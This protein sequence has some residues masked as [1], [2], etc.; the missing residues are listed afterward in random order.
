M[1]TLTD[2]SLNL[3]L[4]T[5]FQ[6][7]SLT[8]FPK[9]KIGLVGVNGSGKTTLF[10]M[11]LGQIHPDK[12][13]VLL[14]K[15]IRIAVVEQETPGLTVTALE[16]VRQGDRELYS[17]EEKLI[18]AT[19]KGAAVLIAE[20]HA[21]IAEIDGYSAKSRAA[22]LLHGLGFSQSE[23]EQPV[24]SFSGG[25]RMRLN[26]AQALMAR[27]D[28]LL[29]D[30]PTNHL[31]LEAIVWLEQYLKNYLGTLILVSHDREF[32][33]QVC[34]DTVHV[35]HQQLTLYS[36]NYSQFERIYAEKLANQQ[37]SFEKQQK[38]IDH[39]TSFVNRFRAKASKAKQAQ[40]RLKA[41]EKMERV[42]EVVS[43]LPFNFQFPEVNTALNPLMTIEHADLGYG[44]KIIV[45]NI[46][47]QLDKNAR[48]GLLG[49]NGAGK[50]TFIKFLAGELPALKGQIIRA[51][52]LKIGYFAQHQLEY[53]NAQE[54]PLQHLQKLNINR[55]SDQ[56][57]RNFLGGFNFRGNTVSDPITNFSGGEKA[58][59]ALAL[60]IWQAPHLLLLDEPTNHLDMEMRQALILALQQ[61]QGAMVIISHD[62]YLLSVTV[63][64]FLMINNEK[65]MPFSGDLMD[66]Q[67]LVEQTSS[68][69]N[70]A[71]AKISENQDSPTN[72]KQQN[73]LHRDL[74][75]QI[76]QI[77][78]KISRL[79]SQIRELEE[80]LT[81]VSL[82]DEVN[83]NKLTEK[84][85]KRE[86]L[87][88]ELNQLESLWEELYEKLDK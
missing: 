3:G 72:N 78:T 36:G 79:Q 54:S 44:E 73:K 27:S 55:D 42:A 31:D 7:A 82:Y 70:S 88:V 33:D 1:L 66:Y 63:D 64:E 46:N 11:I 25:W 26:L 16:Y 81:D 14:Q 83:K 38:K 41:L 40:S 62:R 4:K 6:E 47:Y 13:D 53:L 18:E 35:E 80:E 37:A 19:E 23:M 86:Q 76:N 74:T 87:K 32:L 43:R 22:T 60:I 84:L 29:L 50:S 45:K 59:L 52:G 85:S 28:L 8:I 9:Q 24:K 10:A 30:E 67:K 2:I 34:Q 48:L 21:R 61:Y 75:K 58:R 39:M 20:Y 65:I 17:L 69:V 49:P 12:G 71:F 57:L 15:N 56:K 5:I 68:S 77:E 51:S